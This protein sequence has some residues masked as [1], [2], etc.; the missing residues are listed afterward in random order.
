MALENKF[1]VEIKDVSN[2]YVMRYVIKGLEK[3]VLKAKHAGQEIIRVFKEGE[4]C[5]RYVSWEYVDVGTKSMVKFSNRNN[6]ALEKAFGLNKSGNETVMTRDGQK[7]KVN[8]KNST[9]VYVH[10]NKTTEVARREKNDGM[11]K[12]FF[13]NNHIFLYLNE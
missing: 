7:I 8:F 6:A 11:K 10:S 9:A 1:N 13:Y 2:M 3:D 5:S 12:L 4:T